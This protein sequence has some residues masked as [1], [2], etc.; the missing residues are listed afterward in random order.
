MNLGDLVINVYAEAKAAKN[1]RTPKTCGRRKRIFSQ[2]LGRA[3][4]LCLDTQDAFGGLGYLP[5]HPSGVAFFT[6]SS[7]L[8]NAI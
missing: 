3:F 5:P 4:L 7:E 2:P 8:K 6:A 1:R